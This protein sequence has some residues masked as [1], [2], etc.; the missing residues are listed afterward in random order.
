M[1]FVSYSFNH[2]S[3]TIR[4]NID[5]YI[6][7]IIIANFRVSHAFKVACLPKLEFIHDME[8]NL[9]IFRSAITFNPS[10]IDYA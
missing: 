2:P 9:N 3:D 4:M 5:V 6:A 10:L 7:L 8:I 1:G